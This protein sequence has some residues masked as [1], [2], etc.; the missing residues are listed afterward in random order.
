MILDIDRSVPEV[1]KADCE[2]IVMVLQVLLG[3]SLKY[4]ERG[5]IT[6]GLRMIN[7]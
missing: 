5:S 1:F 7:S 3:N 6:V 2:R 4:T